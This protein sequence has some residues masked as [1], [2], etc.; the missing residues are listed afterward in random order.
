MV[1]LLR[2]LLQNVAPVSGVVVAAVSGGG[3]VAHDATLVGVVDACHDAV[4][5]EYQ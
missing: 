1:L 5:K 2:L 3:G 4:G